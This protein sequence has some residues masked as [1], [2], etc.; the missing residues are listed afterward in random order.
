MGVAAGELH[1]SLAS[2]LDTPL[3][4][5]ACVYNPNHPQVSA[6]RGSKSLSAAKDGAAAAPDDAD[7]AAAHGRVQRWAIALSTHPDFELL[8][9]LLIFANCVTLALFRPLEPADGT[10]NK[11]LELAGA[12]PAAWRVWLVD[13]S[14]P[15]CGH[16]IGW[17][18]P[19]RQAAFAGD[20][21]THVLLTRPRPQTS[22]STASSLRRCCCASRPSAGRWPTASS[23]GTCSTWS[24]CGGARGWAHAGREQG[25]HA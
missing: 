8:V 23:L 17:L 14:L 12:A 1:A 4:S 11:R 10:H 24:W 20:E 2:K 25:W 13:G 22:C 3:L 19:A 16:C 15:V 5:P 6:M 9:I 18:Q 7:P 21:S